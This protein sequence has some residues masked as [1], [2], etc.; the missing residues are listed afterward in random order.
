MNGWI[1]LN[2]MESMFKLP[3]VACCY[4]IYINGDLVYIGST[5][6]LRNRFSGHAFGHGYA[7]NFHAP[8]CDYDLPVEIIL[9]YKP[10]SKYGDWLMIEARLIRKIRPVFNKKLKGRALRVVA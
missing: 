2:Y 4:C 5:S 1:K 3:V 10:S 7:K 8:W 9:K 6:D